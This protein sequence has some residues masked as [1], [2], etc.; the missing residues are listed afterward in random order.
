[1]IFNKMIIETFS[2]NLKTSHQH[3]M[4]LSHDNNKPH[5]CWPKG[6]SEIKSF[7]ILKQGKA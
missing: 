3:L 2:V 6:C 4:Q 1:M 7:I 5:T